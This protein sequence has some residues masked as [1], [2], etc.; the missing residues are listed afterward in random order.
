MGGA[1]GTNA[2]PEKIFV[3]IWTF[4]TNNTILKIPSLPT[5]FHDN[6]RNSKY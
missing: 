5:Y 2:P 3:I 4:Q 1:D 6:A